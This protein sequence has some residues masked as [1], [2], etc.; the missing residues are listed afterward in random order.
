[1]NDSKDLDF[2]FA[3]HTYF[4]VP[5]VNN[6]EISDLTGLTYVDKTDEAKEKVEAAEMVKVDRFT[7]RVYKDAP[8]ACIIKGLTGGRALTLTKVGMKL[9]A[10][11]FVFFSCITFLLLLQSNM[12]DFVVWNPWEENAKK[13]NDFD[14]EEYKEMV[15]VEAVQSSKNIVVSPGQAYKAIHTMAVKD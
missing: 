6:V 3:L 14:D 9:K 4:S 15:C 5:S 1:M 7:D 2:T 13:L 11:L 10:N 12:V 8:D